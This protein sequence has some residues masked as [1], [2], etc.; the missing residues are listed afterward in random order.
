MKYSFLKLKFSNLYLGGNIIVNSFFAQKFGKSAEE[1]ISEHTKEY[2][3][4]ICF[5]FPAGHIDNNMPIVLGKKSFLKVSFKSV[6][7][8]QN[9]L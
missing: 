5:G 2:N 9:Y 1:I 6:I 3:F 4:P 8:Q 7:L